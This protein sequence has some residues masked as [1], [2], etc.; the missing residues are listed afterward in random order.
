[1]RFPYCSGPERIECTIENNLE[2]PLIITR[3]DYE[4]QQTVE[5][6]RPGRQCVMKENMNQ[7]SSAGDRVRLLNDLQKR[8]TN[9]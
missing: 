4:N 1:M 8:F 6:T 3:E 5:L 2:K 9:A 7:C